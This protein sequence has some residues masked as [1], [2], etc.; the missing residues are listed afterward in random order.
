MACALCKHGRALLESHILPRFVVDWMRK[1][2]PG[3]LRAA[4]TPNLRI[5]DAYKLRLLCTECEQKLSQWE[6]KFA[7]SVFVPLHSNA[8]AKGS[9]TL[10]PWGSRFLVSVSWR[11]AQFFKQRQMT[12]HLTMHQQSELAQALNRWR[13]F[14]TGETKSIGRYSQHCF[15]VDVIA[16]HSVPK[17][18]PFL[19]RYL[20]GSFDLDLIRSPN[21][22]FVYAKLC[23]LLL[24]G[25]VC[26]PDNHE[27][28][29]TVIPESGGL[30]RHGAR[31]GLPRS[32][33]EYLNDRADRLGAALSRMSDRQR[34]IIS[35]SRRKDIEKFAASRLADAMA[36]D[37]LFSGDAAFEVTGPGDDPID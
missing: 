28:R 36:A 2:S 18:S 17:L 20:V 37:V 16:H 26:D 5:Q 3:R 13:L 7:E 33:F 24:F 21:R 35:S 27:W 14:L 22:V 1:N 29:S 4:H 10:G 12:D 30:F 31:Y 32:M 9:L 15:P 6:K 34:E 19:N 11:V 8:L 25:T 23:Q